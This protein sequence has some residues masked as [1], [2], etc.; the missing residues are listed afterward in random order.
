MGQDHKALM[1]LMHAM[2]EVLAVDPTPPMKVIHCT[3]IPPGAGEVKLHVMADQAEILKCEIDGTEIS[4]DF[5][6]RT[7]TLDLPEHLQGKTVKV[8]YSST[9]HDPSTLQRVYESIQ[10]QEAVRRVRETGQELAPFNPPPGVINPPRGIITF[11]EGTPGH[12]YRSAPLVKYEE[13]G[14]LPWYKRLWR[15]LTKC[16]RWG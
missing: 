1:T 2:D 9:L 14:R 3:E 13:P 15:W 5:D 16:R 7:G 12:P 6:P 4:F 10:R 8:T 11:D